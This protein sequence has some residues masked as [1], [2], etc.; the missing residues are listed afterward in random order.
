MNI[1]KS[2][3]SRLRRWPLL[4][5]L[6]AVIYSTLQPVHLQELFIGTKAQERK[7]A[8]RHHHKG[9]DWENAQRLG[10][11]REW[12]AGYWGSRNNSHRAFLLEKIAAFSPFSTV[13]E[14]GC[15]CGPSLY[16]I[17]KR[18]PDVEI[19]GIDINPGAVKKGNEL[20][21]QEGLSNVKLSVGKADE[22]GQFQ[23]KSFDIVFTNSLL[24]YIGPDKIKQVIREMVRITNRALLLMERYCFQPAC[25]D[26]DGLGV[27][28]YCAWERDYVALL[29]QFVP[30]EQIHI[31]KISKG[32]WPESPR[33]EEVGAV[34]EV[35]I[36]QGK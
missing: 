5:R 26:P 33:W 30:R 9:S 25:K 10:D 28:R 29:S 18:F 31:T 12:V 3:E 20:F 24:M 1:R 14:I 2:L 34:I 35:V 17:A 4:Y 8:R 7:W 11:G 36:G 6:G 23:D 22:L 15:N 16:P 13:L 19:R 21:G 27:Y 32:I